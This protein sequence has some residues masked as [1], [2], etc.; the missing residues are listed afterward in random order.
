MQVYA[1]LQRRNA[2]GLKIHLA[3]AETADAAELLAGLG[4]R[5]KF[6][7]GYNN[8]SEMAVGMSEV[9]ESHHFY[10]VLSYFRFRSSYYSVS[11]TTLVALDAVTLINSGL[12]DEKYAWLKESASVAQLR[13][14]SMF[15]LTTVTETFFPGGAPDFHR[16]PDEETR[17]RWRRRYFAALRRLQQAGIETV[18]DEQAG[19]ETYVSLRAEWD[20]YIT[21]LAPTLAYDMEEID[22]AGSCP[23][24]TDERDELHTRPSS[25]G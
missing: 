16:P 21:T 23:K 4:P 9:K 8:L 19:A 5:G 3:T 13:R 1:A 12:D 10:A 7:G 14:S 25:V 24:S 15:L 11:Q 22:P 6:D 20:R 2:L 18:A 17:D